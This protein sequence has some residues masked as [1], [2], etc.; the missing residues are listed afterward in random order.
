MVVSANKLT[1]LYE[2]FQDL[3]RKKKGYLAAEDLK[4]IPELAMN[5]LSHR[6]IR[7]FDPNQTDRINFRDFVRAL[8]VFDPKCPVEKKFRASFTVFDCNDD[9]KITESDLVTILKAM[10]GSNMGEDELGAIARETISS[11]DPLSRNYLSF[12]QFCD[13]C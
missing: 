6:I 3:D 13:V 8:W 7:L 10:V 9:D 11:N 1:F 2:R 5:P 4:L 12:E